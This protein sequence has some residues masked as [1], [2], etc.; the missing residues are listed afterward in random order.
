MDYTI[1]NLKPS[2]D[3][4][5]NNGED[6]IVFMDFSDHYYMISCSKN[7]N[8]FRGEITIKIIS[9]QNYKH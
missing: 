5:I 6:I 4:L 2:S 8:H 1:D 3:Y 9:F 7:A